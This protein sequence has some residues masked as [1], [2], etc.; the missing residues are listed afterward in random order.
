[1]KLIRRDVVNVSM[2]I[3]RDIMWE[4]IGRDLENLICQRIWDEVEKPFMEVSH[5]LGYGAPWGIR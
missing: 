5:W 2:M 4:S 3:S 1:M